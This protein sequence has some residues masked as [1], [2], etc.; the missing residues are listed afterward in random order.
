LI[1]ATAALFAISLLN[2]MFGAPRMMLT[3]VD[4]ASGAIAA[5]LVATASLYPDQELQL[6]FA[7]K[8]K[9][10]WVPHLFLGISTVFALLFGVWNAWLMTAFGCVSGF[11]YMNYDDVKEAIMKRL[12]RSK[13]RVPSG[14]VLGGS[15]AAGAGVA[16]GA[17]SSE[18]D[19]ERRRALAVKALEERMALL[20]NTEDDE[21]EFVDDEV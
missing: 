4:G 10:R 7:L 3:P 17:A 5:L 15:S 11:V 9:A 13:D 1:G 14:R 20:R 21:E 18:L 12:G 19:A 8:L 16:A 6:F 2:A